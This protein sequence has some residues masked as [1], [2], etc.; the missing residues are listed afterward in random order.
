SVKDTAF[1]RWNNGDSVLTDQ[2]LFTEWTYSSGSLYARMLYD[3]YVDPNE[4]ENI[5]ED[6]SLQNVIDTVL[7][8][9]LDDIRLY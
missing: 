5:A 9:L 2:Y 1:C 8:P 3:H 4:N 6:S 7:S